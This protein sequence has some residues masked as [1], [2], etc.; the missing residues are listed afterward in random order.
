MTQLTIKQ[1][2]YFCVIL[3]M[4]YKVYEICVSSEWEFTEVIM[5]LLQVGVIANSMKDTSPCNNY[6]TPS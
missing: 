1:L 6:S 4:Q 5:E 2:Q 3:T